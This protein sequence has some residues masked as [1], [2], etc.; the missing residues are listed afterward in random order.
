MRVSKDTVNEIKSRVNILDVARERIQLTKRGGN[1][2]GCCPFHNEK[3]PS[4]TIYPKNN[5]FYCFGCG[6]GGDVIAFVRKLD[7]L[8]YPEAVQ[9][10][11]ER[12]GMQV[13]TQD[14]SASQAERELQNRIRECNREAARYYYQTLTKSAAGSTARKYLMGERQMAESSIRHFGVGY[15]TDGFF[16][17]VNHLRRMGFTD[18]E[19]IEANVAF[20]SKAGRVVDRFRERIMFPIFDAFGNVIGF[21]GR[22]LGDEKPKYLNTNT[23]PVFQ[24]SNE[25]FALNFARKSRSEQ[26]ILA[27][28]YMD[29]IALHT[30]GF[31]NAVASLGT[32]LTEQHA[33]TLARY[34]KEVVIC[35]DSDEA[36]QKATLKAIS[37]LRANGVKAK[38]ARIPDAKD[39]D[40]F[41][42]RHPQDGKE[43]LQAIFD[44]APSDTE[45]RLKQC[46]TGLDLGRPAEKLAYMEAAVGVLAALPDVV[47]RDIYAEEISRNSGVNKDNILQQVEMKRKEN[48]NPV[49]VSETAAEAAEEPTQRFHAWIR[50]DMN[51]ES[52]IVAWADV[53]INEDFRIN[54]I[55]LTLDED[56]N[57]SILLPAYKPRG[58]EDFVPLVEMNT[59]V[60]RELTAFLTQNL[61]TKKEVEVIGGGTAI[62]VGETKIELHKV[63]KRGSILAYADMENDIM[64]LKAAKVIDGK[65]GVFIAPPDAGKIQMEDGSE[66][67]RYVYELASASVKLAATSVIQKAYKSMEAKNE[68]IGR[69]QF[70]CKEA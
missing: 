12:A 64:K 24:K 35:Y 18:Q 7:N 6:E 67:Y 10:L 37:V 42:K 59:D 19:M 22:A 36:G 63:Y 16:D 34:A 43:R 70:K 11:A 25:L 53:V 26:M 41:L 45:Y 27:E 40:E 69:T 1:Y 13:S 56:D 58:K 68:R 62:D 3:T 23:T 44:E 2:V 61:D 57:F 55:R 8:T 38:V 47:E 48:R 33:K 9:R 46:K 21:G 60:E 50:P 5:S 54:S 52:P 17:L 66:Q 31:T 28:G 30:A 20:Q 65:H 29:V 49:P 14:V 15:A 39:P 32:A 51:E 4:F